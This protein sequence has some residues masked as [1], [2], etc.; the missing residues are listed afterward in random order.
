MTK[1]VVGGKQTTTQE[2]PMIAAI[3]QP[4]IK[5]LFCGGTIISSKHIVTAAHCF[6][7]PDSIK[8]AV[9]VGAHDISNICNYFYIPFFEFVPDYF[10]YDHF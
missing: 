3:I 1:K 6:T 5:Q 9:L 2:Y 4:D 8:F 10:H 7:N